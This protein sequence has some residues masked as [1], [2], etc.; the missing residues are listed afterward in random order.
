MPWL[1]NLIQV[2][3]A[4]QLEDMMDQIPDVLKKECQ[5]LIDIAKNVNYKNVN[6]SPVYYSAM[7]YY[8]DVYY[9]VIDGNKTLAKGGGYESNGI[10]SLGFAIYT[11]NL[12]KVLEGK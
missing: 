7:K 1:S 2:Q 6:I 11:D 12:L 5:K 3:T 10:D 9:R 4:Q 8:D